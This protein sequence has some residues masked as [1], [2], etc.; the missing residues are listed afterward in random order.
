MSTLTITSVRNYAPLSDGFRVYFSNGD[1][2]S[3]VACD[4]PGMRW[5]S[6]YL[7][8]GDDSGDWDIRRWT[9]D[10]SRFGGHIPWLH[11]EALGLS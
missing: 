2:V 7:P 8:A 10:D 1:A 4:L 9:E 11:L 6:A 5:E 3:V